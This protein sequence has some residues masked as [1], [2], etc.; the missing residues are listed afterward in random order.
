MLLGTDWL[1]SGKLPMAA[2]LW[3]LVGPLLLAGGWMYLNDG[4]MRRS[5]V[6]AR[7]A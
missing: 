7:R 5:R 3:W 2:G 6:E 1:E 4:R